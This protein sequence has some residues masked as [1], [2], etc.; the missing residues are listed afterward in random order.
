M[1][2]VI[3]A[4]RLSMREQ[5]AT[6]SA[7]TSCRFPGYWS[8]P[9]PG[10]R[11]PRGLSARRFGADPREIRPGG[12]L[13]VLEHAGGRKPPALA[14]RLKEMRII[15]ERSCRWAAWPGPRRSR[16]L[17]QPFPCRPSPQHRTHADRET[18]SHLPSVSR[19]RA[20]ASSG[21]P[22]PRRTASSTCSTLRPASPR[23]SNR[24]R[25]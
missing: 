23:P 24:A 7:R 20:A 11:D 18:Y 10:K 2:D 25:W 17:R 19:C 4:S 22:S 1:R 14:A 6:I 9:V 12:V 15:S 21:S 13:G 5:G 8:M 3:R 16:F